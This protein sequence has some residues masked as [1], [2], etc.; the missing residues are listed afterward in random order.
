MHLTTE[1]GRRLFPTSSQALP[2]LQPDGSISRYANGLDF[3]TTPESSSLEERKEFVNAFIAGITIHPDGQRLDLQMRKIPAGILRQP[4]LSSVRIG[5][6]GRIG[7]GTDTIAAGNRQVS[8][9][10][11]AK[12]ASFCPSHHVDY[13]RLTAEDAIV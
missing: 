4:G 2:T 6:G 8:G 13:C 5:S 11:Q 3:T 10:I 9:M 7:V 12:I 1:R